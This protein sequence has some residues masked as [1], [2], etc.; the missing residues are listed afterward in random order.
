[1]FVVGIDGGNQTYTAGMRCECS[2]QRK[3]LKLIAHRGATRLW[4]Q[5]GGSANEVGH[6]K[7]IEFGG[8]SQTYGVDIP[9]EIR[10]STVRGT[11]VAPGGGMMA[12]ALNEYVQGEL[13]GM[14][15][16][17]PPLSL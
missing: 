11:G 4:S 8:F 9:V 14:C 3:G 12:K 16:H 5:I 2:Q 6:E 1:M 7:C 17:I 10:A 15:R 13:S